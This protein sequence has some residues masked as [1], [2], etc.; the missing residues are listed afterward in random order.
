M[1]AG[2]DPPDNPLR[3][4]DSR[5]GYLR[6]GVPFLPPTPGPFRSPDRC[7]LQRGSGLRVGAGRRD[8]REDS[9]TPP[10]TAPHLRHLAPTKM[11]H[12]IAPLERR[13]TPGPSSSRNNHPPKVNESRR[14]GWII[15]GL[16]HPH[17]PC[18]SQGRGSGGG[19]LTSHADLPEGTPAR[20]GA[21]PTPAG[22]G[23]VESNKT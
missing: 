16:C 18:S 12:R 9:P 23:G 11:L 17:H 4:R 13:N 19:A 7:P 2:A 3:P 22:E 5:A 15:R 6:F 21:C 1:R 20:A 8:R 10:R 14:R